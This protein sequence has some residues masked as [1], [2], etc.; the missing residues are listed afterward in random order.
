ML[1]KELEQINFK[2]SNFYSK[3]TGI[4]A[5]VLIGMF[6]SES[7]FNAEI[8][9]EK[10]FDKRTR[11]YENIYTKSANVTAPYLQEYFKDLIV[12][13]KLI[14]NIFK[15]E[16]I[17]KSIIDIGC[18]SGA[19]L[20]VIAQTGLPYKT[21]YGLDVKK[22]TFPND[23]VSDK[24]KCLQS[25]IIKFNVPQK[26]ELAMLDNVY[27][28][29]APDDKIFFMKSIADSLVIGGKLILIIPHRLFG[30]ADWTLLK[31]RTFGGQ[32]KAVCLHLDET[33]YRET[34]LELKKNGFSNFV[35]PIPFI[36]L[37]PLKQI[38]P[39]LR[40]PSIFFSFLEDSI[41]MRKLK[42]IKF[43]GKCLF[44]M[45]VVIIAEKIN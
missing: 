43:R 10:D 13:K 11:L 31:D 32:E 45:E 15:K 21:L 28:H 20:Y 23:S 25:S 16:C 24:I 35:S 34:I 27:E 19:F 33:T 42:K 14:F 17:G 29:I 3:K 5:E 44:R 39:N 40:F 38:F 18:G 26:F 36:A 2:N 12:A 41:L 6:F 37:N 4:P 8:L 30:P 7:N 1:A 9:E 22:P